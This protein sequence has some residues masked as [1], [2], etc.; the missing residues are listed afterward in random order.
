[1]AYCGFIVLTSCPFP[2]IPGNLFIIMNLTRLISLIF[3]ATLMGNAEMSAAHKIKVFATVDQ[4]IV[5]GYAYFSSGT[6][7]RSPRVDFYDSNGTNISGLVGDENGQ[8]TL[9]VTCRSDYLIKVSTDDGHQA[10]WRLAEDEFGLDLPSCNP[11]AVGGHIIVSAGNSTDITGNESI[12]ANIVDIGPVIRDELVPLKGQIARLQ[13][14][15]DL[16]SEKRRLQDILGALGYL[17]GLAGI[18][19]Y[20]MGRRLDRD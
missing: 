14:Q 10:D 19:F 1:M 4:D 18:A 12:G 15:I 13:E 11:L 8:F 3:F 16:L 9:A 6:R 2:Q 5:N 7:V 17:L 20:I